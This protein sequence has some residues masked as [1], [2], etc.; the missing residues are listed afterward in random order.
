MIPARA[1]Q[2][3]TNCTGNASAVGYG[4]VATAN[5]NSNCVTTTTPGSPA[6][7]AVGAIA[8]ANV[9]A[10]MA[11]DRRIV[12]RC[13][14]GFRACHPLEPGRYE[15]ELD[16]N[17]LWIFG[18]DLSGKEHKG[19]FVYEGSRQGPELSSAQLEQESARLKAKLESAAQAERAK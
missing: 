2:S 9:K 19:K 7:T 8:Q 13:Q 12:L 17:N 16:G 6:R 15:A 5:G 18:H 3:A 11:D 10:I 4:G 1:S 14:A